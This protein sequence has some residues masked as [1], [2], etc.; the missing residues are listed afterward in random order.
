MSASGHHPGCDSVSDEETEVM[1]MYSSRYRVMLLAAMLPLAPERALALAVTPVMGPVRTIWNGSNSF[2]AAL[3]L[4]DEFRP[5]G[6]GRSRRNFASG[7][8]AYTWY[9]RAMTGAP[10]AANTS[11]A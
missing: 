6:G 11:S 7:P 10:A 4:T 9:A 8:A 2:R 1:W 3:M 5:V